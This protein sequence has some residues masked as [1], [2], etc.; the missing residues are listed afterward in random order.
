MR[1]LKQIG[2]EKSKI[3]RGKRNE[4]SEKPKRRKPTRKQNQSNPSRF[5][6]QPNRIQSKTIQSTSKKTKE[7]RRRGQTNDVVVLVEASIAVFVEFVQQLSF[8]PVANN[9]LLFAHLSDEANLRQ[10]QSNGMKGKRCRKMECGGGERE[11][12]KKGN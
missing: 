10:T 2:T 9:K 6:N 3:E 7:R 4:E 12:R 1:I 5:T 8:F 11:K